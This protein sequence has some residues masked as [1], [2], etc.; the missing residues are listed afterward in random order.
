MMDVFV[1]P[2]WREGM[3]RS[4]IEAAAM[5]KP[6]VLTDIRGCREVARHE[7]EGLLVP[8][9]NV[10]QLGNALIC[11]LNDRSRRLRMGT[12][13]RER[14]LELFDE[15]RIAATVVARTEGLLAS[16]LGE[17]AYGERPGGDRA[18]ATAGR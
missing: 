4:A 8:P 9:R 7:I 17:V 12:A 13:A 5:G 16:R 3:P 11:M 1:L 10:E 18:A 15:S 2:S 6:L 14:A